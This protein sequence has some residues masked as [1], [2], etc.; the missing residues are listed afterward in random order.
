[1]SN[2]N[3]KGY[4]RIKTATFDKL[5]LNEFY[6][7]NHRFF[8]AQKLYSILHSISTLVFLSLHPFRKFLVA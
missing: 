6:P 3:E 5:R 2:K 1:M 8:D 7:E 4:S